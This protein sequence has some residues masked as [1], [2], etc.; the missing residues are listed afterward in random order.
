MIFHFLSHCD[1]LYQ[2]FCL[3]QSNINN[4]KLQKKGFWSFVIFILFQDVFVEFYAP[5]CG[6][7]YLIHKKI[8]NHLRYYTLYN[9]QKNITYSLE[10]N[11]RLPK[12]GLNISFIW[13]LQSYKIKS[14]KTI[15]VISKEIINLIYSWRYLEWYFIN[16]WKNFLYSVNYKL[17]SLHILSITN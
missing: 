6:K 5:W 4:L 7:I 13:H 17:N 14:E 9:K 15:L 11:E 12:K 2:T 8:Q 16:Y 1:N 10:S 3:C